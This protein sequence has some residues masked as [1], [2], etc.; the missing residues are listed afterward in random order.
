VTAQPRF[1]EDGLVT[2]VV[3]DSASNRVLMVAHMNDA[4][5]RLTVSTRR[6]WFWSR[7]RQQLWEKGATSGNTMTVVGITLDCD[8]DAVVLRVVPAGPACHTGAESCFF[9]EVG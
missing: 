7:S 9:T 1:G 3:Q 8:A 2:A 6:A 5:W 4:A